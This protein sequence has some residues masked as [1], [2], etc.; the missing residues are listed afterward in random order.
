MLAGALSALAH[1][2]HIAIL[3]VFRWISAVVL[4]LCA[5]TVSPDRSYAQSAPAQPTGLSAEDGNTQVRLRWTGPDDPTITH[6]QYAYKLSAGSYPAWT[7]MPGSGSAT[8]RFTVTGLQNN[9]TYKF[10]IRAV[11]DVGSGPESDEKTGDPYP[12]VPEKPATFR[13][14]P[15]DRKAL[16]IWDDADD[17]SIGGWEYRQKESGG[18][19]GSW[20]FIP[21]SDASTTTYT[22]T[23]LENGTEYTFQ[24]QAWNSAGTG[25]PSDEESATPMP[26]APGKPAGLLAEPGNG[27]VTLTWNDPGNDT[28]SKWQ[29]AYKTT[30]DFTGWTDM[31]GSGAGTVR[32]VVSMLDNDT[33]YTFKV[34]AVNDVGEGAESDEASVTPVASAPEKPA[35]LLALAGDKQVTLSW[36]D[37]SDASIRKWQYAYRT[38]GGYGN[39]TD[40]P[41]S[42][43]TTT[44]HVVPGLTNGTTYTFKLRAVN[45]A[46][47]GP[48]SGEVSSTPLAVPAKPS[49]FEA[50]AG[51]A[52]VALA[53]TDP[54]NSTITRWQYSFGTPGDYSAWTDIA[55]SHAATTGHIVTGL[56]NGV[57]HM[58]KIRAVNA[59]G[60]GAASVAVA[61]TPQ[62]VP[63]KPSGLRV[64]AGNTQARLS[65]TDPGDNS[66][67]GWQYSLKTTGNYGAWTDIP[68]SNATTTRYTVTGLANNMLHTFRIRAV[69]SSGAG[70]RVIQRIAAVSG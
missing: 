57:E 65:W 7:D 43:A 38:A 17:V 62:P 46:G 9:R 67:S 69:N 61:A 50:T 24:I 70:A 25:Y 11:N 31:A 51:E 37:P 39:W 56:T 53:W 19:D 36:T 5:A 34:R 30:G 12:A 59:S 16:L 32:H 66:I 52:Q 4:L 40:I 1:S 10:K 22:V 33:T 35:G 20:Q 3:P 68:G 27:K 49:G 21:G 26:S 60:N 2:R 47:A 8:R 23:G 48:Q 55:G 63:T 45:D 18:S 6:W 44:R 15:G 14:I 28:I 64:E 42:D 54:L 29:Y 13:A 58:F 41:D